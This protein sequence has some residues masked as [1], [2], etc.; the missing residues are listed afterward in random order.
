MCTVDVFING[1]FSSC[2][3]LLCGDMFV[4]LWNS[5]MGQEVGAALGGAHLL[6]IALAMTDGK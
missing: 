6:A 3:A 1:T 4:E 5:I 2:L